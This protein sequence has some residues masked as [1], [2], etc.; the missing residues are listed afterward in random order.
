M[1][2]RRFRGAAWT[3]ALWMMAGA[4]TGCSHTKPVTGEVIIRD[5]G[6]ETLATL[7]SSEILDSDALEASIQGYLD[8]VWSEAVKIMAQQE[9]CDDAEAETL[10]LT[11]GYSIDTY[12][13]G[14]LVQAMD[15]CY[16]NSAVQGLPFGCAMTDGAGKLCAVYTGGSGVEENYA[17]QP[18]DPCSAFKPLS[19]FAPALEEG[20]LTWSTLY[21]D[22]PYKKVVGVTGQKVDWPTNAS[23]RYTYENVTVCR[24]VKE[25]LNTVAVKCLSD[26]GV[27]NA[28]NF[29]EENFSMDLSYEREKAEQEGPDEVIGNLALGYPYQ[30]LSVVDMAGYY[31]IFSN[32]GAY[33]PPQAIDAIVDQQGETVYQREARSRQVIGEG[34]AAVMNEMLQT[35]VEPGGTG[36]AA[37]E[38]DVLVGGKTGTGSNN[39][40]N[41]FVGFVPQYTC[42]VW[43]EGVLEGNMAAW[44]FGQIIEQLPLD[45]QLDFPPKYKVQKSV[46]CME[47][48]L[49][50]SREC[51]KLG[52]GYYLVDRPMEVCT[53]CMKKGP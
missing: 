4:M 6:G 47:S 51:G 32:A 12:F 30:G 5:A 49:L 42:A 31:Q 22:S 35:V 17:T 52:Q 10:L 44:L 15:A 37:G 53:E 34:T 16:R 38:L 46:Y 11:G 21:E 33:T 26:Y 7:T 29:L 2:G 43:Y 23:G 39:S 36:Q 41:W 18:H 3:L 40:D 8:V 9:G 48:G 24:A 25:S 27:V 1:S 19:V 13:D 20:V 45:L 28:L 14:T 50:A